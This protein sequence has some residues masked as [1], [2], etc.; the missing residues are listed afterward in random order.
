MEPWTHRL[1][2]VVNPS[3]GY[4]ENR[5]AALRTLERDGL[6]WAH[7]VE[8][9][10]I[11]V[12]L[13]DP[14]HVLVLE[15][16][17]FEVASFMPS[18]DLN[19][20]HHAFSAT[21]EAIEPKGVLRLIAGFQWL[22]PLRESYEDARL[23]ASEAL[24]GS[25]GG[26]TDPDPAVLL[27]AASELSGAVMQFECGIVETSEIPYRL[28]REIGAIGEAT[29]EAPRTLWQAESLPDVAFFSDSAMFVTDVGDTPASII[30]RWQD[31]CKEIELV[32][33]TLVHRLCKE[34]ADG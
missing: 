19:R 13:G 21:W 11:S 17:S 29:P 4:Y 26:I 16:T 1:E 18:G 6:L 10:R 33:L 14:N 27:F 20:L 25:V 30:S 32:V 7:R 24:L 28:S 5:F 23:Y 15:P 2:V 31:A 34:G 8:D 3:L 9:D 22:V 12:R